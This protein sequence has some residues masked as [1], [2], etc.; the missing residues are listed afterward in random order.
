[1][2]ICLIGTALLVWLDRDF[3]APN[4]SELP[5]ARQR[6]AATDAARYDGRSFSVV[7]VV[8]GDT[9]HLGVVD[10]T[11]EATKV[12]LVGIDAP[13]MGWDNGKQMYYAQEATAFAR[14]SA[15]GR[16]VTVYLDTQA[17]SRDR[18]HRL[19]AYIRL[20]DGKFLNEELL[21]EGFAYADLRFKHGYFQKYRQL[22]AGARALKRGLWAHV[23]PEQMPAWRQRKQAE[24]DGDSE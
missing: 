1:M 22:E 16:Q 18:Y 11:D 3:I 23:K 14:R 21:S 2:S 5:T 19:L 8:D 6:T 9:L 12:R 17:G 13:E 7:R 15:L 4:W 10:S 20:P 24:T